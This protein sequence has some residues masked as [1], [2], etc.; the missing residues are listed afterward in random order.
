M[1]SFNRI[2][3]RGLISTGVLLLTAATALA[4][5]WVPG[6]NSSCLLACQAADRQAITTGK[7][8]NGKFFTVCRANA[9]G[10]GSRPGF[11]LEPN[12]ANRCYVA[13]GGER[14]ESDYQC[15]CR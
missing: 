8:T 1:L 13:I 14:A 7:Y 3:V 4:E 2:V 5:K 11:N 9:N 12:W 10:E 6:Q 15:L